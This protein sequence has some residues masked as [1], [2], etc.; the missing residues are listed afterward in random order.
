MKHV[1]AL[2]YEKDEAKKAELIKDVQEVKLPAYLNILEDIL[3]QN[4]GGNGFFAGKKVRNL[5]FHQI[6]VLYGNSG[7]LS[8]ILRCHYCLMSRR[9]VI[10]GLALQLR[11]LRSGYM[12]IMNGIVS[13][14]CR[15]FASNKKMVTYDKVGKSFKML[16]FISMK[17]N[18]LFRAIKWLNSRHLFNGG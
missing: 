3:K 1:I 6:V 5:I 2:Y 7:Y 16:R 17:R 9:W 14:L 4:D 11:S 12:Y 10:C 18:P 15:Y 13:K 8:P